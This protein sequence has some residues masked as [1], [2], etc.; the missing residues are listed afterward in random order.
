[1]GITQSK[2]TD[3]QKNHDRL[4]QLFDED[5]SVFEQEKKMTIEKDLERITDENLKHRLMLFQTE[6]DNLF[7]KIN[8]VASDTFQR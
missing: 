7:K 6:L 8:Q 4:S 2:I 1:M 3:W 5:R